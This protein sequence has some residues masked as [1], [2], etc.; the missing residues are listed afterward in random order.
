MAEGRRP[1]A[2]FLAR[3]GKSHT[4]R[5][6]D[7]VFARLWTLRRKRDRNWSVVIRRLIAA[8]SQQRDVVQQ[9][10]GVLDNPDE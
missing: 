7:E 5:V 3:L 2:S 4:I 10:L 6:D 1:D 8:R 9:E